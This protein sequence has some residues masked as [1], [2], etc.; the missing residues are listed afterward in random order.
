MKPGGLPWS[1]AVR[2][3]DSAE[4]RSFLESHL[5]L[6]RYLALR[7]ASR[8]PSSVE[9]EDLTHDGVVGL[10]EA[11]SSFDPARGVQFR[12]YAEARIRGAILDGLRARDWR[13]RSVH[14]GRRAL[15]QALAALPARRAAEAS[16]EEIAAALGLSL[17]SYRSLLQDVSCGPLLSIEELPPGSEPR[18]DTPEG[19]PDNTLERR[20]LLRALA[21]E[22][23]R[24]PE[25]ERR[26]LELY[27][28]A[29]LNMK[30]I[31]AVLGV[32]ESRVCQLHAQAAARLRVALEARL[33]ALCAS[34][35]PTSRASRRL[36]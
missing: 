25:R 8:L 18:S 12:T 20:D 28:H 7:I 26:V 32:T 16:E 34:T 3:G 33:H 22:T 36:P 6:V 9:I 27:Y 10:L 15:E 29:G 21:E 1:E 35:E 23:G 11:A 2:A 17:E 14:R 31:G 13:P 4:R 5:D 30:E 19:R 24:L